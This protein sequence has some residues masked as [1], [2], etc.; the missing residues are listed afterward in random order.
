MPSAGLG[1]GGV[2]LPYELGAVPGD[3]QAPFGNRLDVVF[4]GDLKAE[5]PVELQ[6]GA[7][8]ANHDADQV[9]P[10]FYTRPPLRSPET[11]RSGSRFP[12]AG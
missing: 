4:L 1:P 11:Y 6:R 10:T 3:A 2:Y 9:Q 8:V 7:H 5:A 12:I